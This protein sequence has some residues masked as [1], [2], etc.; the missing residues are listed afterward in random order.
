MKT[1][2]D[3]THQEWVGERT[4]ESLGRVNEQCIALLIDLAAAGGRV[5]PPY[6]L[7]EPLR[8]LLQE[9]DIAARR[10]AAASPHL[11]LDMQ[12]RNTDWWREVSMHPE[13]GAGT[14]RGFP[15]GRS[16]LAALARA[17]LTLVWHSAR[18]EH[19]AAQVMM[20]VCPP[21]IELIA[22]FSP[23]DLNRLAERHYRH[24]APRWPDRPA[25]WRRLLL[26]AR[27]GD[28]AS[29]RRFRLQGVQLLGS[30]LLAHR[31]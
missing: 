14:A 13:R 31:V 26:A 24:L 20:G 4:L 6:A 3:H 9:M 16:R 29:M 1:M 5:P 28:P 21:V 12:F 19:E 8:L 30:E 18:A 15:I 7:V 10:R 23:I 2:Q 22:A 11:L 27:S 17:T 25:T